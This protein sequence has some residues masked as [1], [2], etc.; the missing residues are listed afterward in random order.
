V[1][2][3]WTLLAVAALLAGIALAAT[4]GQTRIASSLAIPV[5]VAFRADGS[6]V[7]AELNAGNVRTL[8]DENRAPTLVAHVP[9]SAG[10]NGGFTGIAP[11]PSDARTLYVVYSVD[12]PGATHGK[13]NRVSKLVGATETVLFDDIPWADF[14]DGGRIALGSDGFL[15]VSTGDNGGPTGRITRASRATTRAMLRRTR[16]RSPA[17]SS[18]SPR[19][20]PRRAA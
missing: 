4:D 11:D 15:Y 5:D 18:A 7:F 3:L 6:L 14:H 20:A 17:R 16:S 19:A 2:T 1:R 9:A 12:K 10:G 13:V 8:P